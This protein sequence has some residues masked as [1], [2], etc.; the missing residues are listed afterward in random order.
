[1]VYLSIFRALGVWPPPSKTTPSAAQ[2]EKAS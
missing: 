2:S 1:V